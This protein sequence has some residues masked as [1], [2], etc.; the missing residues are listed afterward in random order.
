MENTEDRRTNVLPAISVEKLALETI[1]PSATCKNL[2]M[3]S[4]AREGL[5]NA[6]ATKQACCY[7]ATDWIYCLTICTRLQNLRYSTLSLFSQEPTLEKNSRI[8]S[9]LFTLHL[10]LPLAARKYTVHGLLF[11][12]VQTWKIQ[13]VVV[14]SSLILYYAGRILYGTLPALIDCYPTTVQKEKMRISKISRYWSTW[15]LTWD[16]I[17][18]SFCSC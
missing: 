17:A 10:N 9:T 2:W 3:P 5:A 14:F 16:L 18:L 15:K 1:L 12:P 13:C 8:C 11:Y 6:L 7:R 4:R